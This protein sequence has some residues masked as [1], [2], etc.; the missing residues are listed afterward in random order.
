MRESGLRSST[1]WMTVGSMKISTPSDMVM[2][3]TPMMVGPAILAMRSQRPA[4]FDF[5]AA[6]S[7]DALA[8]LVAFFGGLDNSELLW[9]EADVLAM[10]RA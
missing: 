6:T 7:G 9:A 4:A 10:A 8:Q 5:L 2:S 1:G 3:M